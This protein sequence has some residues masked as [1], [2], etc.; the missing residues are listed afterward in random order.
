[1]PHESEENGDGAGL[2]STQRE[3]PVPE[4]EKV[5]R[6]LSRLPA[7]EVPEV[8]RQAV[9]Q[10][11]DGKPSARF[12]ET[13]VR[14]HVRRKEQ[15]AD[16][17][18]ATEGTEKP[19]L[20]AEVPW[21]MFSQPRGEITQ[22]NCLHLFFKGPTE[23]VRLGN[24]NVFD[25]DGSS[26]VTCSQAY[27][28]SGRP[29]DCSAECYCLVPAERY[30]GREG[31]DV[32][33]SG[34]LQGY[35][36]ILDRKNYRLGPKT[37]FKVS[38]AEVAAHL[39]KVDL[40]I[41]PAVKFLKDE[42]I[43]SGGIHRLQG[44]F[45]WD[46]SF[47]AEVFDTITDRGLLK[48]AE[49]RTNGTTAED[50]K[51]AE[52]RRAEA[53]PEV[54]KVAKVAYHIGSQ[55]AGLATKWERLPVQNQVAFLA[56]SKWHL[57]LVQELEGLIEKLNKTIG[58]QSREITA[59][60]RFPEVN[61]KPR[62][63]PNTRKENRSANLRSKIENRKI[64]MAKKAAAAA[65]KSVP[66][67][68]GTFLICREA[69]GKKPKYWAGPNAWTIDPARAKKLSHKKAEERLQKTRKWDSCKGDSLVS[70]PEAVRRF[71]KS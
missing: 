50:A 10:T 1:L 70:M 55:A 61:S 3:L 48:E 46:Y 14:E 6:P 71:G 53:K 62:N 68:G 15:P 18:E 24:G 58:E 66:A 27:G 26:W 38:A 39:E 56:I 5:L 16:D 59:L 43:T 9:E 7:E 60:S 32:K 54:L 8:W 2:S 31:V 65:F 51:N 63:T 35:R 37:I 17:Q 30:T 45:K 42:K 52:L 11:P 36:A 21:T 12:T 69:D 34:T 57:G 47:S 23:Y 41:P 19:K 13:V 28:S 22:A 4:S 20:E 67:S 40:A 29:Q 64:T 33:E 25:H 49:K 44:R